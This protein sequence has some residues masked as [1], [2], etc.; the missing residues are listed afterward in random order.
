[1]HEYGSLG[2]SGDLAPL[3]HCALAIMGEGVV[4]DAKGSQRPAAEALAEAGLEPVELREKE[5]L[6]LINGTDGMLGMLVLAIADLRELLKV[7]DVT[8][9]DERGRP[10]RQ[11]LPVRRRPAGAAPASGPGRRGGEHAGAA[12]RQRDHGQ[13][14]RPRVHQGAGRLLAALRPAGSRCGAGTPPTTPRSWRAASWP[15]RSTTP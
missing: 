1:M 13:P 15:R 10:A 11:R 3:A 4:R 6:A 5:G 12:G 2:C 9:V 7:A 8:A 14:P